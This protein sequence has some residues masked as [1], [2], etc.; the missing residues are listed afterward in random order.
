MDL[1]NTL[2]TLA[3][4]ALTRNGQTSKQG[5]F[6]YTV[7]GLPR[8]ALGGPLGA[9]INSNNFKYLSRIASRF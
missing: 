4:R 5:V 3:D 6:H 8:R 9:K 1:W 7:R 2:E